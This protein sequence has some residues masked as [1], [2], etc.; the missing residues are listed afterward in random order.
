M[1]RIKL[2]APAMLLA[3]LLASCGWHGT[4]TVVQKDFNKAYTSHT[5][6]CHTV[7]KT[8]NCV[9]QSTYHDAEW[10]LKVRDSKGDEH[11]VEVPSEEYS[12]TAIGDSFTNGV[13]E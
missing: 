3:A 13:D 9:P 4:G 7:G 10:K 11:W 12:N 5:V 1:S 2:A 8:T 6:S